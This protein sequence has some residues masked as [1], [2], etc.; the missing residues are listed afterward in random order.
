MA[1]LWL[2]LATSA[3]FGSL[4]VSWRAEGNPGSS[5]K[6]PTVAG[7]KVLKGWKPTSEVRRSNLEGL[8]IEILSGI[9]NAMGATC[10]TCTTPQ[11]WA[12]KVRHTVL[13]MQEEKLQAELKKRG[14][15]CEGC[16]QREQYTDLM[17][18]SV[19]LPL[20]T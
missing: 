15:K 18:D 4:D 3:G 16:K 2:A 8:S 10:E 9:V 20:L 11:H 19:H 5:A 6:V 12:S 1:I 7:D 17:L 13:E 14:L